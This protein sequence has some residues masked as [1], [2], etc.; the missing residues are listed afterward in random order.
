MIILAHGCRKLGIVGLQGVRKLL[1]SGHE[2]VKI[3]YEFD[4]LDDTF[5]DSAGLSG[6]HHTQH[7][8]YLLDDFRKSTYENVIFTERIE[9]GLD[10]QSGG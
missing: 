1:D 5:D 2:R 3:S 4:R 10:V 6:P 7:C 9:V 8:S